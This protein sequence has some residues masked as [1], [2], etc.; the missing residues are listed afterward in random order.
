MRER[1]GESV[2]SFRLPLVILRT[3]FVYLD[4]P[5]SQIRLQIA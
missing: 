2:M 4:T 5:N 3:T 1:E